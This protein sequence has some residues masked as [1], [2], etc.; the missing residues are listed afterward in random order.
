MSDDTPR[1][2]TTPLS[3]ETSPPKWV[4]S[5]LS[6]QQ[7][8]RL[9]PRSQWFV[10]LD[11]LDLTPAERCILYRLWFYTRGSDDY[12]GATYEAWPSVRRLAAQVSI[13]QSSVREILHRCADLGLI[14][15]ETVKEGER[16][17]SNRYTLAWPAR[18]P[19]GRQERLARFASFC[20]A[21]AKG[22]VCHLPAGWGTEHVGVGRCRW[23][24][25]SPDQTHGESGP[26]ASGESVF[27]VGG[28]RS[29]RQSESLS[30]LPQ[31]NDESVLRVV[32]FGGGA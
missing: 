18:E 8:E 2:K 6:E 16:H 31:G 20:Q 1:V 22:T 17:K 23:H 30:D 19:V 29:G 26:D 25:V 9:V 27:V 11:G 28:V 14:R 5:R 24:E 4:R 13:S 15:I 32:N 7:R 3:D 21:E 10:M 12:E